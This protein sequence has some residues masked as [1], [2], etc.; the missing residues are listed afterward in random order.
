MAKWVTSIFVIS[1][2]GHLSLTK[3]TIALTGFRGCIHKQE[4]ENTQGPG[5]NKLDYKYEIK[6]LHWI[7]LN[8]NDNIEYH[9]NKDKSIK[10][11]NLSLVSRS[12]F[13][14]Y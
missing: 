14:I 11:L 7:R 3:D 9:M 13:M 1:E 8:W 2:Q 10:I 6:S 12:L 4:N 5:S